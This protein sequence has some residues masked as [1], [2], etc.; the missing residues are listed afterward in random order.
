MGNNLKLD[1][2]A[3]QELLI[4]LRLSEY[5]LLEQALF[6]PV[7]VLEQS[8]EQFLHQPLQALRCSEHRVN[9]W[10]D[11][12]DRFSADFVTGNRPDFALEHAPALIAD[13]KVRWM[14]AATDGL[15]WVNDRQYNAYCDDVSCSVRDAKNMCYSAL[16]ALDRERSRMR[17]VWNQT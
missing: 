3:D 11:W 2:T 5:L 4:G 14:I 16:A 13:I 7:G 1:N 15:R 8:L 10:M 6:R 9:R 12:I 17:A